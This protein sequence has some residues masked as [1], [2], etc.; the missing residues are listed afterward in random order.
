MFSGE[1]PKDCL[2]VPVSEATRASHLS[3]RKFDGSMICKPGFH[4]DAEGIA[5]WAGNYTAAMNGEHRQLVTDEPV[6]FEV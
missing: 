4:G 6:E 5:G 3:N 2:L 1:S